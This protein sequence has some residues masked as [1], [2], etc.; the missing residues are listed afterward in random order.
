MNPHKRKNIAEKMSAPP[1]TLTIYNE[2]VQKGNS[3]TPLQRDMT[4]YEYLA[5][6]TFIRQGKIINAGY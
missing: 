5:I 6:P 4:V 1:D 3:R 2:L